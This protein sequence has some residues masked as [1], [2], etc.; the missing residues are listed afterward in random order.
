[1]KGDYKKQHRPTSKQNMSSIM[2]LDKECAA[3]FGV[4]SR[5]LV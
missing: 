2:I 5:F 4:N 1:M 3:F